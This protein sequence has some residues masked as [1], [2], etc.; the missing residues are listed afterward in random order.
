MIILA[1]NQNSSWL[2]RFAVTDDFAN[3]LDERI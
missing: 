3:E 1:L 2:A